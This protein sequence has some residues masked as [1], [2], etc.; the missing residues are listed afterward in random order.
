[1][2]KNGKSVN[3]L[4]DEVFAKMRSV[5]DAKMKQ[6]SRQGLGIEK[7][8]ADVITTEIE[9]IL[10]SKGILGCSN[11]RTLLNT[12]VYLIG[13][14]FALR[15]GKEHR[16]LRFGEESQ[17]SLKQDPVDDAICSTL[18]TFRKQNRVGCSTEKC[19][20]SAP[21]RTSAKIRKD[22]SWIYI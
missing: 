1:M 10:W 11:P 5:L 6:L 19:R 12:M 20:R 16:N 2:R 9:E 15:A 7:N 21:E 14:H 17:I 4:E 3:F 22:V 8:Q 18:K 13:L